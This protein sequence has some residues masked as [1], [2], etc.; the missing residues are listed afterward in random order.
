MVGKRHA[1]LLRD[2]DGYITT[3]KKSTKLKIEPSD[4]FGCFMTKNA[5]LR[6]LIFDVD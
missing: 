4:F 3:M 1:D 5:K 6:R 2:I